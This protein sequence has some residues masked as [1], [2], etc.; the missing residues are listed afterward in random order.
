MAND[1]PLSSCFVSTE[2]RIILMKASAQR[3][4]R[5]QEIEIIQ[6][7]TLKRLDFWW[8]TRYRRLV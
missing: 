2:D 4:F 7:N 8:K 1:S 3:T 5:R 6:N